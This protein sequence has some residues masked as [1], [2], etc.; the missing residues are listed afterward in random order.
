MLPNL[1]SE[2]EKELDTRLAPRVINR[3]RLRTIHAQDS[4]QQAGILATGPDD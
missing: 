4:L 1:S 2:T 3:L